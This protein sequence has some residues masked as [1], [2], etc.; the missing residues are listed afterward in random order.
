[1]VYSFYEE[2]ACKV[3]VDKSHINIIEL[4]PI[5]K[6]ENFKTTAIRADDK[7]MMSRL[8]IYKVVK[9]HKKLHNKEALLKLIKED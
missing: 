9:I 5:E 8:E 6:N 2:K 1:M 4:K 7:Y 3:F